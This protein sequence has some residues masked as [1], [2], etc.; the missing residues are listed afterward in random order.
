[1]LALL[2]LLDMSP[3]SILSIVSLLSRRNAMYDIRIRALVLI[4][5][6]PLTGC[7]KSTPVA[8]LHQM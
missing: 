8:L 6:Y 4:A 3:A 2:T 1:M 5:S 7:K